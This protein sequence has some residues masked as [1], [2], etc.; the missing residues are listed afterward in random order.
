M[1]ST[2]ITLSSLRESAIH[3]IAQPDLHDFSGRRTERSSPP[4]RKRRHMRDQHVTIDGLEKERL[5]PAEHSR[6][7]LIVVGADGEHGHLGVGNSQGT[8]LAQKP[9]SVL[10]PH[11]RSTRT[12]SSARVVAK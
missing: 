2:K 10:A 11:L 12:A 7:L 1:F 5:E 6:L 8:K 9:P 4:T 3:R